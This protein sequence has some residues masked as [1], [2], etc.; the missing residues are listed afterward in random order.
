[1]SETRVAN[2][3]S[4]LPLLKYLDRHVTDREAQQVVLENYM[5]M[6]HCRS[7][8]AYKHWVTRLYVFL[9]ED[10]EIEKGEVDLRS[11]LV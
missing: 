8:V 9:T 4:F 10:G 7:S 6:Y 1:M 2:D 5:Y 3:E 11:W